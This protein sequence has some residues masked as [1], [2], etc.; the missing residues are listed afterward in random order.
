[1]GHLNWYSDALLNNLLA[2]GNSYTPALVLG[3][4]IF[5]V[6][7]QMLV[8]KAQQLLLQLLLIQFKIHHLH[9]LIINF[10]NQVVTQLQ[11]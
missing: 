10:V 2:T 7:K 3:N 1:M 9:T 8:V 4:N 11:L 5:Y 6:T